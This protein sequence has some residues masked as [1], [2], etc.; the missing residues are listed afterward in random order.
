[1]RLFCSL[2]VCV[3][4]EFLLGGL[5]DDLALCALVCHQKCLFGGVW[6]HLASIFLLF[7]KNKR[8]LPYY[9]VP[10]IVFVYCVVRAVLRRLTRWP[11]CERWT[12]RR[13]W[14][15]KIW[16]WFSRD[17][18][19]RKTVLARASSNL[20]SRSTTWLSVS[21]PSFIFSH[22]LRDPYCI[23]GKQMIRYSCSM[24][25]LFFASKG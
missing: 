4:P 6:I 3:S 2:S 13:V 1:V 11:Y 20:P 24:F 21:A 17:S 7:W 16:P 23:K 18:E 19:P 12:T 15:G 8:R 9:D 5:W 10:L 25:A 14:D 22:I